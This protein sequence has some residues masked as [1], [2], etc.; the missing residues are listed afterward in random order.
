MKLEL[1]QEETKKIKLELISI[2]KESGIPLIGCI[3][4]GIIDRGTNLLQVRCTSFCNMNCS[5]CSTAA[6]PY[7]K[8]HK[9]NYIVDIDYLIEEVERVAKIKGDKLI[10]FLD[11]V[12][13][14]TSHPDF[15]KL[16]EKLKKIKEV[17]EVIV[18]TNGTLLTKEKIGA[19]ENAGLTRINLSLHSLDD[20]KSKGLFG[21]VNYNIKRIIDVVN[22]IK[23]SK[24]DLMITPVWLP[25]VNDEDIEEIIRFAKDNECEIGIQKYEIYKYSRKM[26]GAKKQTYWKFYRRIEEWEKKYEIKLKISMGDLNVE[27]RNRIPEVFDVGE[28]VNIEIVCPGWFPGQMIGKAKGR[29]ISVNNCAKSVGDFVRVK[30]SE[31][32]N[33]IYL[34]E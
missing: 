20:K 3:A 10:I 24:I 12:G 21:M 7:S 11:S 14:P 32:K 2:T 6:G 5:F 8:E 27:K 25:G 34:A 17:S 23:N 18:I 16:V 30:I 15:V 1:I 33:N 26:K 13:E 4:F 19:L 31:N 22:Y 9:T 28:K 29:C